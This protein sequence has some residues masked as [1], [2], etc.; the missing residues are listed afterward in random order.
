[1]TFFQNCISHRKW[2]CTTLE[3]SFTVVQDEFKMVS[4][5][6]IMVLSRNALLEIPSDV[7]A[8]Y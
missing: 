3:V 6:F 7:P 8:W 4:N 1:M 5:H 2:E